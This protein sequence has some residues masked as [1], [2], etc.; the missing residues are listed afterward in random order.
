MPGTFQI[1]TQEQDGWCWAAVS[2]SVDHYFSPQSTL[3]QCQVAQEVLKTN[4][5]CQNPQACDVPAT[6]QD[7]LSAVGRLR[8]TLQRALDF[9]EIRQLIDAGQPVC[10]RI[11]WE[12]GGGHFVVLSGYRQLASGDQLVE[13]SDPFFADSIVEYNEFV[14]AYQGSGQWTGTFLVGI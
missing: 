7:A 12:S 4:G 9:P 1:E 3:T 5:C 14:G 8:G 11:Q 13:V 6:L 10:V 2:A